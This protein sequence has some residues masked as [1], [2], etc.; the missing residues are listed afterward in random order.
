LV[1]V[2]VGKE[3]GVCEGKFVDRGVEFI[4]LAFGREQEDGYELVVLR[5]WVMMD[6]VWKSEV[7]RLL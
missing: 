6:W 1:T 2:E 4:R 5:V 3:R 7:C